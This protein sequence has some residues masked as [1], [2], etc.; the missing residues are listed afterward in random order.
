MRPIVATVLL[1]CCAAAKAL[2]SVEFHLFGI[3]RDGTVFDIRPYSPGTS[4]DGEFRDPG[5][6]LR[7][8]FFKVTGNK[9]NPMF[10]PVGACELKDK[11]L[12]FRCGKGPYMLSGVEY[13]GQPVTA[14]SPS[15]PATIL[16]GKFLKRF[17]Y[18]ELSALFS[19]VKGCRANI[20]SHLILVW[21]GD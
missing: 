5:G 21:R 4:A 18:G 17:E 15:T 14:K 16:Y 2:D 20:P 13:K 6:V 12:V 3:T 11:P 8:T 9:D 10:E 1:L 19:C 7:G